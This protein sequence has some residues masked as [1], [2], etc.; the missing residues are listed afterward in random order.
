MAVLLCRT[1]VGSFGFEH[2]LGA[3]S[4]G[5]FGGGERGDSVELGLVL[6]AEGI[7][8]TGG[9]SARPS[10]FGAGVCF[11]LAG[12]GG[13][14]FGLAGGLDGVVAFADGL[15]GGG[16]RGGGLRGS[17]GV[18]RGDLGGRLMAGLLE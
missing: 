2:L 11:A 15:G 6:V 14:G 9:V 12:A 18:R 1:Q 3:F 17:V 4:A 7:A 5:A 8:F 10:G 13:T 16:L